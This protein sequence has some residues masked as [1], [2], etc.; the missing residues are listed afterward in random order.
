MIALLGSAR[1]EHTTPWLIADLTSLDVMAKGT[2]LHALE[3]VVS[4]HSC[5]LR[6]EGVAAKR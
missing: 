2:E 1:G 3:L 6:E 4:I 5:L